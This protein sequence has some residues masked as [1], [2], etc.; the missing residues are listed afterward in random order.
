M[1]FI[2]DNLFDAYGIPVGIDWKLYLAVII[3]GLASIFEHFSND[4]DYSGLESVT[5]IFPHIVCMVYLFIYIGM[6]MLN[7]Y[8]YIPS[9]GTEVQKAML[10]KCTAGKSVTRENI[11]DI[12]IDCKK[13][14]L[15]MELKSITK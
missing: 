11:E 5:S 2:L 8:D 1:D 3:L 4:D 6:Y 13:H 12:M 9:K 14:D 15:E 10:K 7:P